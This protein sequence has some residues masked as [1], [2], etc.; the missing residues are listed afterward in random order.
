MSEPATAALSCF[1]CGAAL[2]APTEAGAGA[3][4]HVC[5]YCGTVAVTV[6][7][8]TRV[9]GRASDTAP[10]V[11]WHEAL[12]CRLCGGALP[13]KVVA[14]PEKTRCGYCGHRALLRPGVIAALR[15]VLTK[16]KL[17]P[18]TLR[19]ALL[20]NVAF[21]VVAI[22]ITAVGI[23]RHDGT[24]RFH[25]TTVELSGI[26]ATD[27]LADWTV[28][29]PSFTRRFGVHVRARDMEGRSLQLRVSFR[30]EP[31]GTCQSGTTNVRARD[32]GGGSG[33]LNLRGGRPKGEVRTRIVVTGV[34]DEPAGQMDIYLSG[35]QAFP[36]GYLVL[37][38]NALVWL[39][40]LNVRSGVDFT[41]LRRRGATVTMLITG[42]FLVVW[43]LIAVFGWDPVGS[44]GIEDSGLG[45]SSDCTIAF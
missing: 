44:R 45:R 17:A 29:V 35:N 16:P 3:A 13:S 30:H 22:A 33:K 19:R 8:R 40:F 4:V 12:C 6:E 27:V 28:E 18:P 34:S 38:V 10:P 37:L 25:Q 5:E 26:S 20:Y 31:S 43:L 21:F 15:L 24:T 14:E 7:G 41:A 9:A 2:P 11:E 23:W 36:L 1:Q 39:T 42:G 32:S